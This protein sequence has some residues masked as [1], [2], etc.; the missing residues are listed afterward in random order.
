[1]L[2]LLVGCPGQV[3]SVSSC[4]KHSGS[5][6]GEAGEPQVLSDA[7]FWCHCCCYYCFVLNSFEASGIQ[8]TWVQ[9]QVQVKLLTWGESVPLPALR[10][11]SVK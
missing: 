9:V 3:A 4:V 1:M 6:C 7:G 11:S 5:E 2:P 10:F 8:K